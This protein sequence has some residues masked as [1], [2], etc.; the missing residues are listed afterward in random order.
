MKNLLIESLHNYT[1]ALEQKF[2][3][4][5]Q[6]IAQLEE[7]NCIRKTENETL[8]EENEALKAEIAALATASVAFVG[9]GSV[10]LDENNEPEVEVELIVSEEEDEVTAE[11]IVTEQQETIEES[12]PEEVEPKEDILPIVSQETL[13]QEMAEEPIVEPIVE[14]EPIVEPEPVVTSEPVVAKQEEAKEV[15]H[16]VEQPIVKESKPHSYPTQTT[17]FGS[18]VDDI[19]QA[20]SLGDRF[21]FQREL[22]GGN[23][24]LMQK[25]LDILNQ[26]HDFDDALA[27]INKNFDWNQDSSTYEL[28]INVLHR[29]F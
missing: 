6:R 5:E 16:E 25:T 17:L 9:A 13:E 15:A 14:A 27:Y 4:L 20:I 28:F 26:K 8:R 11:P 24:E 22:F 19:R 21:L 7:E 12:T 2:A 1:D 23:G 18:S 10:A 29:R 3:A